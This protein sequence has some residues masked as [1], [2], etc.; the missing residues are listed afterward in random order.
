MQIFI[1]SLFHNG[2][3]IKLNEFAKKI[4]DSKQVFRQIHVDLLGVS[5]IVTLTS[6]TKHGV[7]I[8]DEID[9]LAGE[10]LDAGVEH[11]VI[12]E[13]TYGYEVKHG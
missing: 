12:K 1:Q 5:A 11:F 9:I 2:K 10:L 4:V 6:R 13:E 3:F 7:H 8:D